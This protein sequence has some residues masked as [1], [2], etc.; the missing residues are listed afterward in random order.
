MTIEVSGNTI[1]SFKTNSSSQN[2]SLSIQL[3]DDPNSTEYVYTPETVTNFLGYV[4]DN[5]YDNSIIHRSVNDFVIQGGGFVYSSEGIKEIQKKD[6]VLNEPGNSN[7]AGTIA[8]AKVAGN[9]NSATSQWFINLSDN[10]FLNDQNGG[11]TVF[12]KII[13]EGQKLIDEMSNAE[14]YDG[15]NIGSAFSSLPLWDYQGEGLQAKDFL[16][17]TNMEVIGKKVALIN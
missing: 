14:I 3:F 1:I 8:M 4:A 15:T 10:K 17:I 7:L 11:F 12:G 16:I 13:G 9:P 6:T 2:N 5:S